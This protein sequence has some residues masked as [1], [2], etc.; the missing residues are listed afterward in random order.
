VNI[1]IFHETVSGLSQV[2]NFFFN[3]HSL[4]ISIVY[5]SILAFCQALLN[6]YDDDDA[7]VVTWSNGHV[8]LW[9]VSI[10]MITQ[11]VSCDHVADWW[12]VH[13]GQQRTEHAALWYARRA[14]DWRRLFSAYSDVLL[15]T[16]D[17]GL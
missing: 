11:T 15:P 8:Q 7:L 2:L 16:R 13:G 17:Q 12:D 4:R 14:V 5:V 9:I 3:F 1:D 6:E 10:L